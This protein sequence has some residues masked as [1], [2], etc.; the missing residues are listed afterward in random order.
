VAFTST[1][2]S[3]TIED[4]DVTGIAGAINTGTVISAAISTFGLAAYNTI[5]NCAGYNPVLGVS[6]PTPPTAGSPT[7]P[8]FNPFA[9]DCSVWIVPAGGA[10]VTQIVIIT[11]DGTI[12][13]TVSYTAG[14]NVQVPANASITLSF[15][16]GTV[17]WNWWPS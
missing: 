9:A 8:V 1:V 5:K 15:S 17:T 6:Q 10:T 7:A 16:S 12:A 11:N 4:V 13:Q 2:Q 14:F 3:L